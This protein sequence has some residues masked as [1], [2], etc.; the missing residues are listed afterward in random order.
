MK[1]SKMDLTLARWSQR[2]W[3]EAEPT[4]DWKEEVR[5]EAD[6]LARK[7]Q[8]VVRLLRDDGRVLYETNGFRE[9]VS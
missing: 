4:R 8:A 7:N 5:R 6:E 2:Q 9:D 1:V 3:E